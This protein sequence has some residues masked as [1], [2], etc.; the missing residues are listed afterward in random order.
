ME[1]EKYLEVLE[2]M[3]TNKPQKKPQ[4]TKTPQN[5]NPSI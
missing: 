3:P 2:K 5:Q 4:K 1:E